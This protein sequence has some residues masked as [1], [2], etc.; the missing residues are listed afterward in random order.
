M[1]NQKLAKKKQIAEKWAKATHTS[2]KV[3]MQQ[4]PYVQAMFAKKVD[5][6]VVKEVELNEEEVMWL[7]GK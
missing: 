3:A 5:L 4:M 6:G 7:R 1:A 2:K